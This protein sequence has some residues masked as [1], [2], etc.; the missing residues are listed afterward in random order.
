L[1][2]PAMVAWRSHAALA[3][4][5]LGDHAEA[6]RLANEELTLARAW[7]APRALS[8]ALRTVG[9]VEGGAEGLALLGQAVDTVANSPAKLEHATARTELG[10]ALHR[11]NQRSEAREH[12]RRARELATGC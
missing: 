3:L 4:L 12:L 6:R 7:G 9:L 11:A 2:N 8:T 5:Q 10:A 1:R